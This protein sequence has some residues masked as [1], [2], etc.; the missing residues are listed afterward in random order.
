MENE[1]NEVLSKL[2]TI[3]AGMSAISLKKDEAYAILQKQGKASKDSLKVKSELDAQKAV[4]QNTVK[5]NEKEIKR[6]EDKI[7]K[8]EYDTR[9]VPSK[10]NSDWLI[11]LLKLVLSFFMLVGVPIGGGFLFYF[12]VFAGDNVLKGHTLLG[13]I[14]IA[15]V[16]GGIYLGIKLFKWMFESI[17]GLSDFLL[18]NTDYEKEKTKYENALKQKEKFSQ[19]Q[20]EVE[21]LQYVHNGNTEQMKLIDKKIEAIDEQIKSEIREDKNKLNAQAVQ[22]KAEAKTIYE[23]LRSEYGAFGRKGLGKYRLHNLSGGDKP[24]G[25]A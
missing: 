9:K 8:I 3:R 2:Y 18:W 15:L 4:L 21:S 10:F 13:V 19:M 20:E 12:V 7:K 6:I 22:C 1:K 23:G 24:R 16:G 14:G 5:D 25:Y 11:N 17:N